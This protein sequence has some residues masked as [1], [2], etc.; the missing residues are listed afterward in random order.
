MS[1]D[2]YPTADLRSFVEVSAESHFP[3]QNLP[4]GVFVPTAGGAPRVGVAIGEMVCDLSVLDEA[5]LLD[6][7]PVAGQGIFAR[8]ALNAFMAR[9]R[10]AWS[11]VRRRLQH[12]LRED[13]AELRDDQAVRDRALLPL[14]AVELRLPARIGDY[15][16]FYS[17]REHATNVGT[18]FRGKDNA[19]LENWLHLPVAYHGRASSVVISGTPIRRPRGQ[20]MPPG[21]QRPVFG[22]TRLLDHE[23][24]M[25][26]FVGPGN[27]MGEPIP[28]ERAGDHIFGLVLVN[29][30]SARDIQKWE[31]QPLGP[32]LA[33]N[34]ATSI[35][36]WVVTLEAL[37]PFRCAGPE[38]EFEPL[39]YLR[40]PEPWSYDVR[41]ETLLAT[42]RMDRPQVI[43]RGNYRTLY[44]NICQ[45]LA[46][47]TVGGCP[48][49]PGDLM[50]SGTI[51][52]ATRESR[53]SLLELTWRGTEPL[54][55]ESGEERKFL[56]DGDTMTLTG[57]AQGDGFRVGFGEVTG[58][59]LPAIDSAAD[60]R[61][62]DS[63]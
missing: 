29:D 18:M 14:G 41:L 61:Q 51:S 31:Y 23:F 25:G 11:A 39:P 40:S 38:P 48:V 4:Y 36:P 34:F 9:G 62:G 56:E 32:F 58:R 52:G 57:W 63:P 8:D 49:Q 54:R 20:M 50:A 45:Q 26:F 15:T 47:H 6:S 37:E 5:G 1:H 24:E 22:P 19:L 55:L 21:A 46:H 42:E 17:S 3:I 13:V 60:P 43:G 28:I 35:S 12:L 33:K 7:T 16:D 27:A 44:W 53:G 30:W 2:S 59:I 10:P